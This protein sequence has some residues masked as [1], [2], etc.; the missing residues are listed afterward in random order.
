[1]AFWDRPVT[2]ESR[3]VTAPILLVNTGIRK[4]WIGV[5]G[6]TRRSLRRSDTPLGDD[7]LPG[8]K[9]GISGDEPSGDL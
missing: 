9:T 3:L 7:P 2:D 6:V 1:M 5:S 4:H 8:H